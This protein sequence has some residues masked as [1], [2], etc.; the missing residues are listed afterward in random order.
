MT[1]LPPIARRVIA[2]LVLLA[3]VG[4][5]GFLV[6]LPFGILQRQTATLDQLGGQVAD[7]E[8]RLRQREQ[9]LAE[10]R[11]LQRASEADQTLIQATTPALA[12]AEL[13][14]ELSDLVRDGGGT[15]DSV[16]VLEPVQVAPFVQV[17]L[18]V[19][20]TVQMEGLRS[21]LYA[22]EQHAPVLLVRELSVTETVTYADNADAG[23]PALSTIVE[24]L[25]YARANVAS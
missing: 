19:S 1:S 8:E 24:V 25:G 6:W 21:F 3:I 20:F 17:S 7:L 12:A 5:L 15:L 14:R 4:G 11:L 23:Q 9:L 18:R 16:Q 2:L 13:Q 10:Q 22:I